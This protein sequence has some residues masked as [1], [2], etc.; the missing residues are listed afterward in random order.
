MK[1]LKTICATLLV[2]GA[3]SAQSAPQL[4]TDNI[5][6][7]VSAMTLHEKA[8]LVVGCGM[9]GFNGA[10]PVI[11]ATDDIV[12]GAAGTTTAIPRLGIPSIVLADGPAGLRI[13]PK[14]D[15]DSHTYYCTH[16]PIGTCLS[17]TWNTALVEQVGHAIGE[18]VKAYGVD[19]LLAPGNNIHRNPLCGRNF[20]Y[21][22]ED[23]VLSGNIAASYILGVQSNGVG[24]SLK[25]FALNNQETKRMGTDARLSERTAR[26]IYLRAFQI[27]IE[28]AQPWTVMSSYNRINGTYAAECHDLLEEILRKEWGFTGLVMTDWFG[29]NDRA[30]SIHA[31]ND[32]IEP[33]MPQDVV[34][35]EEAVKKGKLA[36]ADLNRCVK[37][38]LELVVRSPRFKGYKATNAPD[39][40]AH[41]QVTRQSAAEGIVLLEN[42]GALPLAD[43]VKHVA[44]YG[45]TSYNLIAG[46]TGSG[47]VNRAYTV[48]LIEG[49]RN[50]GYTVNPL[51]L[52][53]YKQYMGEW[54]KKEA[55]VKREW[56]QKKELP[57][58]QQFAADEL[59]RSAAANDVAVITLGRISGEGQDRDAKDFNL[60]EQEQQLVKTVSDAYHQAGKKVV[61]VL[62]IGGV[63]E[64]A[65]WKAV[66]DAILLPWQGG[67][68]CGNSIADAL[69]GRSI[70]S[71]H[72]PMTFP[73]RYAD[74]LSSLNFPTE[75]EMIAMNIMGDKSKIGDKRNVDYTEYKEGIYVGYRYFDS[76]R[77]AVS[78]PFGYGLSYT[79]FTFGKP[80]VKPVGDRVTI[81]L[82]VTN[83]GNHAGK[84]V[85]QVYVTA[86]KGKLDKPAQEL[87]AFAKTRLLQPGEAETLTM[88][89][90][91]KD[92]ASY[93]E[94]QHAWV[95]DAGSY[96]F[97]VGDSSRNILGTE[98]ARLPR[99]V[100]QV[101]KVL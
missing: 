66:P 63:I 92:L 82:T 89:V 31:G 60:T 24:T 8:T 4:R 95:T 99:Y 13:S 91:M 98:K 45:C 59:A 67:Q 28:K 5:D 65:S 101:K 80:V 100:K 14:R 62:N 22:S 71:G 88:Q 9:Q 75:G 34:A 85:A 58:E 70:P 33:G 3:V 61:V 84:Q 68:E 47:D 74:H 2:A 78:Y 20:E 19:V 79:T 7:V 48:S 93:N 38:V 27:A 94:Q 10:T 42:R 6:A 46:G 44:V 56:W 32:L 23:P 96:T 77:K 50:N 35:I 51:V 55:T 39:L 21:Y 41:A 49:L 81:T 69:S 1:R 37:R 11:G 52:G 90:A 18:E 16:F 76:Y 54:L 26:E 86:P 64:T 57:A 25:H 43:T 53:A 40:K 30:A 12:Q 72:L 73:V 36:E 87:K 29:G 17:S 15:F 97:R 83:T